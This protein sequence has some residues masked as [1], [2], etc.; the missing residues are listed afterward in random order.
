MDVLS[1]KSLVRSKLPKLPKASQCALLSIHRSLV[2][3]VY[4][5]KKPLTSCKHDQHK[6]YSYF[7]DQYWVNAGKTKRIDVP[8]PNQVWSGDIT[9]IR[10]SSGFIYLSAII[11]L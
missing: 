6:V 5:G 1:K 4:P 11:E 7:L 9:Y 8:K 10:T 2:Y 3:A